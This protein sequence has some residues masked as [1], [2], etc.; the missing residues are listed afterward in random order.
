M[1]DV[2]IA[3]LYWRIYEEYWQKGRWMDFMSLGITLDHADLQRLIFDEHGRSK[4]EVLTMLACMSVRGLKWDKVETSQTDMT[5][6]SLVSHARSTPSR[7]A[8]VG[9]RQM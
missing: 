8:P 9:R 4:K 2:Y 1:M 5:D 6:D 7:S 3:R